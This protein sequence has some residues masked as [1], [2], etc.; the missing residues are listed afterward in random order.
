MLMSESVETCCMTAY[1]EPV[2]DFGAHLYPREVFP[3]EYVGTP[4]Q[5]AIGPVHHSPDEFVE[6][7][8]AGGIDQAVVSMPYYMG[9]D[10]LEAV[11]NANDALLAAVTRHDR[12]YG[13]CS[14]PVGAGGTAA[15][16]EFE[17]CL[18][19]GFHG[20]A[21]PTKADGRELVDESL[22][23]VLSVAARRGAPLLVH[24]KL[25]DSLHPGA[26]DDEYLLNAIFGREMAL[27]ESICKVIHD[28]VFDRYDGLNLVYHHLGGNLG[29]MIG[30]IHLQLDP[31]RWPGRQESVT[32]YDSFV[33]QLRE[34]VYMD[35]SGFFG[36][37]RP[38]ETALSAVP[39]S[40]VMFGT[41][42]PYEP[43]SA[44][45][46]SLFIETVDGVVASE[47]TGAVFGETAL[48]LLAG[49]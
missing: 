29:A 4:F 26:L 19:A 2:V 15:A 43:R 47:D 16:A 34:H 41:D 37:S 49:V 13:L 21:L 25:H 44:A 27:A 17:R 32:A 23:P 22:Q 10:D 38:L 35:T 31:G 42:A 7:F 45:E 6:W 28:D 5:D 14:I 3:E 36:Y 33:A 30:R 9:H 1:S 8:R 18:D 39:P 24:P 11:S 20:G 12:L 48:D 46:L 40:N